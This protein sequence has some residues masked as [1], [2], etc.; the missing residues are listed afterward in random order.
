MLLESFLTALQENLPGFNKQ[1]A[2]QQRNLANLIWEC[3]EKHLQHKK[4]EGYAWFSS[5]TLREKFGRGVFNQLNKELRIFRTTHWSLERHYTIGYKLYSNVQKIKTD[6]LDSEDTKPSRI[7]RGVSKDKETGIDKFICMQTPPRAIAYRGAGNRIA[8]GWSNG[9]FKSLVPVNIAKLLETKER[10]RAFQDRYLKSLQGLDAATALV[11]LAL[12]PHNIHRTI[13]GINKIL[14]L[15]NTDIEGAQGKVIHHYIQC[16]T[17]RL[18]AEGV[19]IQT[20]PRL[21]KHAALPGLWE[22][23]FINCHY[24]IFKQ[25]ATR[26]GIECPAID[27]YIRTAKATKATREQIAAD[28]NITIDEAKE[29]LIALIYGANSF[30]YRDADIPTLI[31]LD[32]SKAL[33]KHP[34]YSAIREDVRAGRKPILKHWPVKRSQYMNAMRVPIEEYEKPNRKTPA[35]KILSHLIQGIETKML[36]VVFQV[37]AGEMILLQHDGFATR[38]KLDKAD[39]EQ[40]V[41]DG[42]GFDIRVKEWRIR[43]EASELKLIN[44][45]LAFKQPKGRRK[46]GRHK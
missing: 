46:R 35:K 26:E 45:F 29:C 39:I 25:L 41:K 8:S 12:A 22:Y 43:T 2:D 9:A 21:I 7:I 13:N 30:H 11:A 28:I 15:A 40:L 16:S 1:P 37:Y 36:N 31:G 5:E 34:D 33:I 3:D 19:T 23:D 32:K 4:Y 20:T 17:G 24:A 10:L 42:A 18:F 27:A 44:K 6:Y 14:R 38:S